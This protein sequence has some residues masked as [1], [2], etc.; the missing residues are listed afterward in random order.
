MNNLMLLVVLFVM[1]I[2]FGGSNVPLVLKQN[3]EMLLG[4]AGGL[5]LCSFFGMKLEGFWTEQ[6]QANRKQHLH[7]KFNHPINIETWTD[8]L[9]NEGCLEDWVQNCCEGEHPG[10]NWKLGEKN[11]CAFTNWHLGTKDNPLEWV[12]TMQDHQRMCRENMASND[13]NAD[14][15]PNPPRSSGNED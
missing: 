4:V 11:L 3:K 15:S 1:F 6:C 7:D 2:Y 9:R 12:S 14:P 8:L 5:V 13:P 10:N